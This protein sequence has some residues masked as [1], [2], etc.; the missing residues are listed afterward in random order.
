[1]S[2]SFHVRFLSNSNCFFAQ[3]SVFSS[4]PRVPFYIGSSESQVSTPIQSRAIVVTRM[5]LLHPCLLRSFFTFRRKGLLL[6]LPQLVSVLRIQDGRL[7]VHS[8]SRF[9]F[10]ESL[11]LRSEQRARVLESLLS[12]LQIR[13]PS[14]QA[15]ARVNVG[16]FL[17]GRNK[18]LIHQLLRVGH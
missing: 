10:C 8:W 1:M 4:L 11:P 18:R 12:R 15:P 13:L 5:Q 2:I 7:Q 6:V 16:R 14:M 17:L 9:S 3:S